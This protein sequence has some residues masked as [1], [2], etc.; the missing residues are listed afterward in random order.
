MK[1][2][3]VFFGLG[4]VM[5]ASSCGPAAENRDAM[6]NRAKVIADSIAN[7]IKTSMDEAAKPGPYRPPVADTTKKPGADTTKKT[8]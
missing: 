1:K 2:Q 8:K 5:F 7:V 4:L 3:I 6:H